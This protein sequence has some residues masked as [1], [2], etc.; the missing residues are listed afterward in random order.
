MT[1]RRSTW[2]LPILPEDVLSDAR[3]RYETE[4]LPYLMTF[5]T[6]EGGTP[7]GDVV[8]TLADILLDALN[9]S[10]STKEDE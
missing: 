5:E 2:E 10:T 1:R 3:D 9:A 4:Q 6:F 8:G 7:S